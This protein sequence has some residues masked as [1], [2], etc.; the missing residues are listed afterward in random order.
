MSVHWQD[1]ILAPA[2]QY[3][4][5]SRDPTQIGYYWIG[6]AIGDI[7]NYSTIAGTAQIIPMLAT[8]LFAG[9]L[10][11]RFNRKYLFFSAVGLQA[12]CTLGWS[13]SNTYLQIFVLA[14]CYGLFY[15]IWGP[16]LVALITDYFP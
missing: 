1:N 15:G 10:A 7:V 5:K 3:D 11:E 13:L 12:L 4:Y 8:S 2:Y 14:M 16:P 9:M 6:T